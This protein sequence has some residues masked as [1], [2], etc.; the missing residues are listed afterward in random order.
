LTVRRAGWIIEEERPFF[1]QFKFIDRLAKYFS[2]HIFIVC[3]KDPNFFYP[4]KKILEWQ[5]QSYYRDLIKM[6]QD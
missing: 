2:P 3:R 4:P 5:D 1:S 6:S